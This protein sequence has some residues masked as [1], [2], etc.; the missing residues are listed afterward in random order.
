[1]QSLIGVALLSRLGEIPPPLGI[2]LTCGL[3]GLQVAA[4]VAWLARFRFGPA[5]W[6][7]RALSYG[8][9]P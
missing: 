9:L 6:V 4:S 5:E 7:W 2:A 8:K 1:M 3:Y